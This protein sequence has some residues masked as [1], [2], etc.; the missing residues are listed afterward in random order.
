M[1]SNVLGG[2]S[3][4][5]AL[6]ALAGCD[7]D[8]RIASHKYLVSGNSYFQK[9]KYREAS[10]LYRRA[11][12]KDP[13]CAE[14]WY[15]LGLTNNQLEIYP[16]ARKD[17]A[18]AMDL[19]PANM[20]AVARLGDLELLFYAA[21]QK[22][23]RALLADVNDLAQRLLKH[24]RN[25]YDGLRLAGEIAL[26]KNNLGAAI[27][28]FERANHARPYQREVV[29]AL[30]QALLAAHQDAQAETLSQEMIEHHPSA[31]AVYDLLYTNYLRTRRLDLAENILRQKIAKNASEGAY[32]IQL[33]F[34][35]YKTGQAAEM[36]SALATLTSR[37][38]VFP[39][40]RL[41]VG[42]FYA[43]TGDLDRA[44]EQYHSGEREN[45]KNARVYRKR[46][47]EVLA[48]QGKQKQAA[49]L[50]AGLLK[51]DPKDAE[52]VGLDAMLLL[53]AGGQSGAQKAIGKLE[54]LARKAPQN[55]LLHYNL[56][57]GYM[58]ADP[59]ALD[60][61]RVQFTEALRIDPRHAP[62]HLSLAAVKLAGGES[63]QA[64]AHAEQVLRQDP[65]NIAARLLRA[66][67]W[68]HM[69][70]SGKAREELATILSTDQKSKDARFEL[71]QL[72]LQERRFEA[73]EQNFQELMT[74]GDAR[75][76][77]GIIEC[78]ARRQRWDEAI[79]LI[80]TQLQINPHEGRLGVMLADLLLRA[81]RFRPAADQYGILLARNP[82]SE[83]LNLR[84]GEAK[85]KL[86]DLEGARAAFER[87]RELAPGDAAP[88]L[89]LGILYDQA[90]R[91]A[92]ARSAYESALRK[93]PDNAAALN[94]LA[95]LNAD[96]GVELDQALA[97]AQR[98]RAKLP[99]DVN[100][101]D[102]LGLIYIKKNLA[103]DGLRMLRDAVQR[104]PDN[105]AF[106]SHLALAR[107]LQGSARIP[108]EH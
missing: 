65:A 9:H 79:Q 94:N 35:Y 58:A 56:G 73:A 85:A 84:L 69:A 6:V 54:A 70:E 43:R 45:A 108:K 41:Q 91:F 99:D 74:S 60:A 47:V 53:A 26:M 15:R 17:F 11:L 1:R 63:A 90:R 24:D 46:M 42:D 39:N 25:S 7:R 50:V 33:A 102:T 19:D 10:L 101:I 23:N 72:D 89:D 66:R 12:G 87:A 97:Y 29:L 2:C 59:A 34:H 103:V 95:F 100:V 20:D 5:L 107:R 96:Q 80:K 88:D 36:A 30:A 52:A 92:D 98:A 4:V 8:P 75:A 14:A 22:A 83:E 106:Q 64:L 3:L 77:A 44:L 62:S 76:L 104:Q 55:V 105:A 93:Q 27:V 51:D 78:R 16:E 57:R 71:A 28:E 81:G 21:D 40:V 13:R 82:R 48:T 37:P 86:N 18:R 68:I 31:G 32:V 67:A 38:A 49:T 61:A